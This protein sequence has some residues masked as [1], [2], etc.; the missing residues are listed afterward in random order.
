MMEAC[1][2]GLL[3]HHLV[4]GITQPLASKHMKGMH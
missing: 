4:V 3:T 1:N 2:T